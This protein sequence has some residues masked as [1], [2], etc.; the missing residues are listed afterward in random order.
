MI[1]DPKTIVAS[2]MPVLFERRRV[3]R[4]AALPMHL[5][6]QFKMPFQTTLEF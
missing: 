1:A 6:S 2:L 3:S 4:A 5:G